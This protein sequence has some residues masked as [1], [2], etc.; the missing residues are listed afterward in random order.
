MN[1]PETFN[2]VVAIG[3]DMQND[4]CPGGAL[5]V[6]NGDTVVSPFNQ[7]AAWT[8]SNN[9]QVAFTRDWH[10]EETRHFTDFGGIWPTHCVAN[11]L[12]AALSADLEIKDE[13]TILDKGQSTEDDGYSGFEAQAIDGS[14]LHEVVQ[15]A[16]REKV[17][18]LI[19][20]LA[21]DYCVKA[22]VL[23]ACEVAGQVNHANH[24]RKLSI[25]VVEDAIRA[26]EI[27]PGDG[28]LAINEMKQAGAR[29]V[30]A[31]EVTSGNVIKIGT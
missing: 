20:G 14:M 8:R 26:V 24:S 10:P 16:D 15:P 28:E 21:T 30:N 23:D 12:G 18:V 22:T 4:F 19:G 6:E 3:V 13:D 17:A 25:F 31:Q 5:A 7:I 2:R 1:S 27:N 29:F 11:T 9:G